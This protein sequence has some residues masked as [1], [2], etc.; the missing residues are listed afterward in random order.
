M[1]PSDARTAPRRAPSSP[2]P[3]SGRSPGMPSAASSGRRWRAM[4]AQPMTMASAPSSSRSSRPDLDHAVERPL[5]RRGLGH[6]H[7]ERP[8]A[9]EPLP[10]A[11]LAQVAH[12]PADRALRDGDDA[13]AFGAGERRQH[14]AF[15]D[16]E[17]RP[18]GA[19]AADMQ[20]GI[21]EAGDDEGVGLRCRP[22]R[23]GAAA[24]PR[25]RRRP[26]SRSRKAPRL[27]VLQTISGPP[28]NASGFS[29][30]VQPAR[31]GLVRV[32]VDDEDARPGMGFP[33]A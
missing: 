17:H 3:A 19:F 8:L 23:A 29:A 33:A 6:A 2:P 9:G 28:L 32:R 26:G 4:P 1:S 10:Q 20:A 14:A 11:H 31:H 12:V 18:P 30:S 7:V 21:G 16:A 13:E 22:R 25:S 15:G 5:A 27:S 24:A